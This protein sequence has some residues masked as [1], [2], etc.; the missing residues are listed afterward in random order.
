MAYNYLIDVD[1]IIG[2]HKFNSDNYTIQFSVSRA[3]TSTTNN[4]TVTIEYLTKETRDTLMELSQIKGLTEGQEAP[5]VQIMAGYKT[6]GKGLIFYGTIDE[7]ETTENDGIRLLLNEGAK[8]LSEE[9]ISISYGDDK[10]SFTT[11]EIVKNI[12][13]VSSFGI[14]VIDCSEVT[15]TRGKTYNC[16]LGEALEDLAKAV[17]AEY[18][19]IKNVLYFVKKGY[20]ESEIEISAN[21]GLKKVRK[22][23]YYY[24][25][26]MYFNNTMQE[27]MKLKIIKSNGEIL[28]TRI[29]SVSHTYSRNKFETIV[30]CDVVEDKTEGESNG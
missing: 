29:I 14:G 27:N 28:N 11:K 25:A 24:I 13:S 5:K 8:E 21:T 20:T 6:T 10:V 22:K 3:S 15:Y 26:E 30:E 4:S 23:D 2:E 7:A 16:T 9:K 12:M 19:V 18:K 1:I 17:D